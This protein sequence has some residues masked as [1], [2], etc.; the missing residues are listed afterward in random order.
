MNQ[1]LHTL[2]LVVALASGPSALAQPIIGDSTYLRMADQ[3]KAFEAMRFDMDAYR[4]TL[5]AYRDALETTATG[6]DAMAKGGQDKKAALGRIRDDVKGLDKEMK[7]QRKRLKK[8][9]PP[10]AQSAIETSKLVQRSKVLRS[11]LKEQ[12]VRLP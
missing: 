1:P 12:G 7:R 8:S 10:F 6:I 5:R 11:Q 2:L 4:D 9:A 3:A